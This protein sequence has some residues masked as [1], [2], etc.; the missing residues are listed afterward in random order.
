[1]DRTIG[2]DPVH[3]RSRGW[4]IDVLGEE[5][6]NL[7]NKKSGDISE[8]WEDI[9]DTAARILGQCPDPK[10]QKG[11]VTGLALGKIQSGKTLSY[12]AL[13]A[14][15]ID[16][17]YRITVVLAGT[18]NPLLEQNY[19]RLCKDLEA[20]ARPRLTPFKNPQPLHQDDE[21]IENVLL[22]GGH[23]LIIVLKNRKRIEDARTILARSELNH[24]PTLI[25]DDEGDEASLNTQFRSGRRS[26][27]YNSILRLRDS[28]QTHAYIA[29][30]ATP[31]APLLISGIDALSPDFGVLIQPGQ[32]YCGG[33]IFFGPNANRYIRE[34]SAEEAAGNP[35]EGIPIGLRRAIA[36][37]LVGGAIRHLRVPIGW[38]SML[39]H[40]SHLR[41]DHQRLQN[42]VRTLINL[43]KDQLGLS[44]TDPAL[45]D[46]MV[47]F[48]A[49]YDDLCQTV[50]N[51]P[52]WERIKQQ[53][54]SEILLEVWMVNS[55]PL[56]RDPIGTP[57]R[58]KNNIL[59]GGNILGRGV[60]IPGLAITYITRRAQNQTNADTMEQR[61]RWFGYK[62]SYLDACR[63]FLTAQ[64]I[65]D[66]TE[67]LRH[68]DDFWDALSR[69]QRQGL[70]I[71]DW[72]RMLR[73]DAGLALQ[74]TRQSV[75]SYRLFSGRGWDIQR[76][77][78]IESQTAEQNLQVVRDFFSKHEGQVR[79]YANTEHTVVQDCSTESVITELLGK[80]QTNGTDWDNSYTIEYLTRLFLSERLLTIDVL[81]MAK[82]EAR[83]RSLAKDANNKE[84][85]NQIDNPM[86]GPT[87]GRRP[88]ERDYYLGDRE[89]HNGR[90]QLQVHFVKPRGSSVVTTILAL[91]IPEDGRY[92]MQYVVRDDLSGEHS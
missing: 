55:L 14:L 84:I 85:P 27:I 2:M 68:E 1:L 32:G 26:A 88:D 65:G 31:Q 17:C 63:I 77:I 47:T 79:A 43:W 50:E 92:N 56:G 21:V 24:Y 54:R 8:G 51:P 72:P 25:I 58:L 78:I 16:N 83:D 28:L 80:L 44:E 39:I 60:T 18:K 52:T 13:I 36:T 76:K 38:H 40:N 10:D 34:I 59:V 61:S 4:V 74:P 82:G 33:S 87:E 6:T 86:Q 9:R 48:R 89:L 66:Y 30:T 90:P 20:T 46:L 5:I 41:V 62:Q 75:A 23:V 49:A 35:T 37:F 45:V 57:F 69:N 12:T 64:L 3:T 22:G 67:L 42:L 81:W 70:S 53:L 73:L 15:A 7:Q 71:R 11:R 19:T 29:Y 91:Y